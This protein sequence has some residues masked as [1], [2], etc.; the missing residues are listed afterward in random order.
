MKDFFDFLK[1][2]LRKIALCEA[3][4][5]KTAISR[6]LM[7][8]TLIGFFYRILRPKLRLKKLAKK[9]FDIRP[10]KFSWFSIFDQV[11]EVQQYLSN[12]PTQKDEFKIIAITNN[13]FTTWAS[14]SWRAR[15]STNWFPT[16]YTESISEF[17]IEHIRI[18]LKVLFEPSQY[19]N[20]W[21]LGANCSHYGKLRWSHWI[22]GSL[23]LAD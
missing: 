19:Q 18:R 6:P 16:F 21:W 9:I 5:R 2:R 17:P 1:N 3:K 10:R 15:R 4:I 11:Q 14:R 20:D 12:I 7:V 8:K 23:F 13:S 22:E